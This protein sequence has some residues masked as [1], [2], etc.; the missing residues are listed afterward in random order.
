M[1]TTVANTVAKSVTGLGGDDN[2]AI[3]PANVG[4]AERI[5]S[6]VGG[7]ALLGY[8]LTCR[9]LGRVLLPLAG[10]ALILRGLTG[11]CGVYA[12]LGV[13]TNKDRSERAGVE[14]TAG[15][16]LEEAV[17][18]NVPPDE[19]FRF[20]RR[21][22]N[23]PKFMGH[24]REVKV[25]DQRRS[26]WVAEGPLGT[27]VAWDAEV[28]NEEQNRLIA[29]Q[30]LPGSDVDT[31]GSVHFT[32]APGGR[33]TEVRVTLK[34]DPPAGK[35]GAWVANLFGEAPE[36]QVRDDLQRFK[37]L[38]EVGEIAPALRR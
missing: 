34:Y 27:S 11:T 30:S 10:G 33:G 22:D 9:G 24:L 7:A 20:W 35:L 1:P 21:L 14:A 15:H 18:L 4:E 29:W 23:L 36:Q 31:A 13:N 8:G 16:K 6:V 28:I 25:L 2:L 19:A 26:H 5:A 12:A 17:T 3:L 37:Q 32:R 38:M